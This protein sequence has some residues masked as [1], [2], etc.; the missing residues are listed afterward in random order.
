MPTHDEY[1]RYM[2]ELWKPVHPLKQ[3]L[4]IAFDRKEAD[5][6]VFDADGKM[7]AMMG[8]ESYEQIKAEFGPKNT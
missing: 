3:P 2:A 6:C 4:S 7:V 8:R 1:T 5:V